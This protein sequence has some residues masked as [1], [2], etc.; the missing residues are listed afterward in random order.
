[1]IENIHI[2]NFRGIKDCFISGI[3]Q[4]NLFFGRNNCGKSSVLDALFL[5]SAAN[6]P[7]YPLTIN[8]SR[9]YLNRGPESL[10]MNFY[11][12]NTD[13]NIVFNGKYGT[14][15]RNVEIEYEETLS[16]VLTIPTNP[17]TSNVNDKI[18]SLNL[19]TEISS[20]EDNSS[21]KKEY[22]TSIRFE[23]KTK[24][25]VTG[26]DSSYKE[27]LECVY[28]TANEPFHNN[29]ELFATLLENKQE[30]F[31]F[32]MLRKVEPNL[33]DIVSA[34]G[35]LLADIGM[36][37]RIPIQL[38]GDGIR[39]LLSVILHIYG[40][41]KKVLLIDEVDNGLHYSAMPTLWTAILEVAKITDTQIFVTT[42]NLDSIKELANVLEE[43]GNEY[44]EMISAFKLIKR[45]TDELIALNYDYEK[46]D[47][48]IKQE[49]EMR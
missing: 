45:N 41:K 26:I 48:S 6:N 42:H 10:K 37:K 38:L 29:V 22:H 30:N 17:G 32:D 27:E 47:Y 14:N 4:I 23:G 28:I 16:P 24:A 19:N 3:K 18:Y 34:N 7:R 43:K 15:I 44:Q 39:K 13:S 36:E 20:T 31:V 5:F 25:T 35:E 1:M 11:R 2:K 9:N 40:S 8:W 33:K 12:L 49:M 46:F 21:Q